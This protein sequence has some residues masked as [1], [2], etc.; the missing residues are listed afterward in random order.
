MT[1][2]KPTA[3]AAKPW[4][5]R[6][7]AAAAFVSWG[8]CTI[9]AGNARAADTA[10]CAAKTGVLDKFKPAAAGGAPVVVP[11]QDRD[12]KQI[13]IADAAKGVGA[14]VNMWATW[15]LPCIEEMPS[16]DRLKAQLAKDGIAVV[17]ISQDRGGIARVEPFFA[18]H[19]YKN[20]DIN[21]DK[22]SALAGSLGVQ[23][24]PTTFLFD[25]KG[26]EVGRVLGTVE[27]D[28]PAVVDFIRD[29]LKGK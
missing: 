11:F 17:A 15:C 28:K 16:L 25:A 1:I 19:G 7:I 18:K 6:T 20:L 3:R 27:W 21:L 26:R 10:A 12:G 23:G 5:V 8:I 29:C 9:G 24:L 22:G 2:R 13:K 14:V 4:L